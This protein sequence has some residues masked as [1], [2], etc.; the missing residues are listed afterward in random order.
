[1]AKNLV[2]LP[3]LL[4][5]GR[6]SLTRFLSINTTGKEEHDKKRD[7]FSFTYDQWVA[8][9]NELVDRLALNGKWKRV[10]GIAYLIGENDSATFR[11]PYET[12]EYAR[13]RVDAPAA[14]V[15]YRAVVKI[16]HFSDALKI[17]NGYENNTPWYQ[18]SFITTNQMARE[19]AAHAFKNDKWKTIDEILRGKNQL[20]GFQRKAA[21]KAIEKCRREAVKL[22]IHRA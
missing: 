21:V 20:M 17:I 6:I 14:W 2:M 9:T 10:V 5:D 11:V 8:V 15:A 1:M 18:F 4:H 12:V 22:A 7:I 13:S 16:G 3:D 19:L